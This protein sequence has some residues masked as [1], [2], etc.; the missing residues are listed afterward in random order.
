M[1]NKLNCGI[2]QIKNIITGDLYIGQS[3]NLNR[4]K[5][6]HFYELKKNAH[7][8]PYMQNSFNKYGES[9]FKFEILLYCEE[10]ELTF[11][12]QILVNRWNPVYNTCKEIVTSPKGVKRSEE[13][14]QKMREWWK[15][16]IIMPWNRNKEMDF[17]WGYENYC[18]TTFGKSLYKILS[19]PETEEE[20]KTKEEYHKFFLLLVSD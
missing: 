16:R 20:Q 5:S 17:N 1:R 3:I 7:H 4:R 14:K 18:V 13:H 2:Y 8:S 19:S 10:N 15:G 11:Y 12:E 9:K 6:Q